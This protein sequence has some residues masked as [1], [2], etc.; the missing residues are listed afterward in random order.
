MK[1][2]YF[3][4]KKESNHHPLIEAISWLKAYVKR[5]IENHNK[6]YDFEHIVYSLNPD[7]E[8]Y[9]LYSH[10]PPPINDSEIEFRDIY[11]EEIMKI[12][13]SNNFVRD[14]IFITNLTGKED[15][16]YLHQACVDERI[17][18]YYIGL[19]FKIHFKTELNDDT[20]SLYLAN[21][22]NHLYNIK[23]QIS[24]ILA[25]WNELESKGFYAKIPLTL[26]LEDLM[27]EYEKTMAQF[28]NKDIVYVG[29]QKIDDRLIRFFK[30][31]RLFTIQSYFAIKNNFYGGID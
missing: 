14:A 6:V 28:K 16:H 19:H 30:P 4:T 9:M 1:P 7:V 15:Y 3:S 31:N 18:A 8:D 12:L 20:F 11:L 26:G 13:Q 23:T 25:G 22:P 27:V 17:I 10:N 24:K 5:F 29:Y 2:F 21:H